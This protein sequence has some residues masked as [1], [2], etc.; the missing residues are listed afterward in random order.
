MQSGPSG[1]AFT[2]SLAGSSPATFSTDDNSSRQ[3]MQLEFPHDI[4]YA[5]LKLAI[6]NTPGGCSNA[7]VEDAIAYIQFLDQEDMDDYDEGDDQPRAPKVPSPGVKNN[8]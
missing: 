1:L 5:A 8:G 3:R 6:M 4:R 2:Q 7:Q